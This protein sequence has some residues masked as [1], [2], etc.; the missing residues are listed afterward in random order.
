MC[1]CQQYWDGPYLEEGVPLD[2]WNNAY[3][4]KVPGENGLAF[5]LAS[6][7]KDGQEGGEGDNADIIHE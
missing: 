3:Q 5:Y 6:L 7:G 4:Y 2:P 1:R